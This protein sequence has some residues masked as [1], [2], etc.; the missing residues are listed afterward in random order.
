MQIK[1]LSDE[2]VPKSR[3][4]DQLGVSRQTVYNHI[5][6]Q[7]PF[8]KPRSMRASKLDAFKGYIR[9]RLEQFDLPST[10]LL[11]ELRGK[12]YRGGI[13]IL[14]EFVRP[15]KAEFVRRVTERF[16]TAPGRQAQ[17]DWGECGTILVGGEKKKLYV[18]VFV[19]GYSRYLFAHFT[20]SCRLPVLLSCLCDAFDVV[21]IPREVLVDNMKQA[22][23]S[24]DVVTGRVCWNRTFLDF[25]DHHGFLPIACPPYWPQ[26]KGK[27]ERGVG[28]IKSSFLEGR[29]FTDLS[30]LNRQL[31][32]WLDLVANAR[33]HGTTRE[34]PC[35][36]FA[37]EGAH[38][39]SLA[40]VPAYDTRP[41]EWRIV[42]SDSHISFLGVRYSVD[43]V[44]VGKTVCIRPEGFDVGARFAVYLGDQLVGT[45]PIRAKGTS[46]VT[47]SA[48]LDAIRR[49]TRSDG[50]KISRKR[51]K[52]PR[53]VQLETASEEGGMPPLDHLAPQVE[54][55]SLLVYEQ[56]VK[57][58]SL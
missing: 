15:L 11:E 1:Y 8:P 7:D 19:L 30:D 26:A 49:L 14:R 27:V 56:L 3:I 13:T 46:A 42:P 51:Q 16:E 35:E 21:G 33:V 47:L 54:I 20:T 6:R 31:Q 32:T 53:F 25:A 52:N 38:L 36:R 4:A 12:G 17:L 22:V 45:H 55:R 57:E 39:R 43:P 18:F 41:I 23:E 28:Y 2:G 10:V 24:H 48:H 34:R 58:V 29:T 9:T 40:G 37:K 5:N 50:P 44:A